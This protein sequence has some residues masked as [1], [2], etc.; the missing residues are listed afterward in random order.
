VTSPA[1]ACNS[2]NVQSTVGAN[3]DCNL[4]TVGKTTYQGFPLV[5]TTNPLKDTIFIY[6]ATIP[7]TKF[8]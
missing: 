5:C 6:L 1:V 8:E 4:C 7:Y 2:Y 3:P